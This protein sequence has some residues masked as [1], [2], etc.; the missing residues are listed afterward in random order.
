[1]VDKKQRQIE[2]YTDYGG[3]NRRQ[4]RGEF[5]LPMSRFNQG[6]AH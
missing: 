1:M 2:D 4:W 3:A 6:S 5:K